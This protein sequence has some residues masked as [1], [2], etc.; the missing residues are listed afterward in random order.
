M[1]GHEGKSVAEVLEQAAD[2]RAVAAAYLRAHK[3]WCDQGHPGSEMGLSARAVL[4]SVA[5]SV[6]L[7]WIAATPDEGIAQAIINRAD[8]TYD[9]PCTCQHGRDADGSEFGM[10]PACEAKADRTGSSKLREAATLSRE[11]S[12]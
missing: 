11:S 10:C 1:T 7:H 2:A 3:A 8:A 9:E 6:G 12:K 5:E 4:L